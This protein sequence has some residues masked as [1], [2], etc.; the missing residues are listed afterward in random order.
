MKTYQPNENGFWLPGDY[1]ETESQSHMKDK[2]LKKRENGLFL[3]GDWDKFQGMSL[4]EPKKAGPRV[5]L[6]SLQESLAI[7]EALY[8]KPSFAFRVKR[9]FRKLRSRHATAKSY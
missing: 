8:G 4:G 1:N 3:P 9:F 7:W 6:S 5:P 2:V